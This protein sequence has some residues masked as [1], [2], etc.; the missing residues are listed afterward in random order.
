[1]QRGKENNSNNQHNKTHKQISRSIDLAPQVIAALPQTANNRNGNSARGRNSSVL[2]Y[3][4]A[5][6]PARM[7]SPPPWQS[8]V[9]SPVN[10]LW[11][12][13]EQILAEGLIETQKQRVRTETKKKLFL[14]CCI[15]SPPERKA[16]DEI[17][18]LRLVKLV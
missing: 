11:H 9:V 2:A 10:K 17:P 7:A 4:Q 12:N 3:I 13:R 14:S 16:E 5:D 1:M 6:A 18:T 8:F 15:R